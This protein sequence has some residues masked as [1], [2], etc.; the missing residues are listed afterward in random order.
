MDEDAAAEKYSCG[1]SSDTTLGQAINRLTCELVG[2]VFENDVT[3]AE[4]CK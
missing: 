3:S 1:A 2:T 4:L